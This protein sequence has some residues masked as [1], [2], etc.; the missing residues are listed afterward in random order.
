MSPTDFDKLEEPERTL[1]LELL[2]ISGVGR[3]LAYTV[4]CNMSVE[5]FYA[6]IRDKNVRSLTMIP[7][8]GRKLAE[9]FIAEMTDRLPRKFKP[10]P[11]GSIVSLTE[12]ERSRFIVQLRCE[13]AND[14]A[15]AFRTA[16]TSDLKNMLRNEQHELLH[17]IAEGYELQARLLRS[18]LDLAN[19]TKGLGKQP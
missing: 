17:S 11:I 18:T 19:K 2:R 10:D 8:V 5:Q 12:F 6:C 9:R 3:T 1:A 14:N 16:A 7:G 13:I 15:K 4:L